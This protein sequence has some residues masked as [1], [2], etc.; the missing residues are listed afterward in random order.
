MRVVVIN[1]DGGG[2]FEFLPQAELLERSEFEALFGTPSGIEPER[3]AAVHGLPT[4]G[5]IA[6]KRSA[7]RPRQA[8]G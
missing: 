5:S 1:N 4:G 8:P 7:T 3:L 2:I 6:S